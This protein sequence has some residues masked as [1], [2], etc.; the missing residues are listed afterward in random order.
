MIPW[1]IV[2]AETAPGGT[3]L[4][5]ARRG[6][7]WEVR[8][9]RA[10]LMSNRAHG[11]EDA[12][13]RLALREVPR[14]S[15]ILLGGLGLGYSL[16]ATLDLLP[17][18]GEVVLAEMSPSVVRWNRT[19]LA[20]LAGRPL[21][22]PRVR[23]FEGDVRD[24]IRGRAAY[25]AILLDVDNGPSAFVHDAN[26]GLYTRAGVRAAFE[27]LRTPGVLDRLVAHPRRA[28]PAAPARG[29]LRGVRAPGARPH[30][31]PQEARADRGREAVARDAPTPP[32]CC[33]STSRSGRRAPRSCASGRRRP[34][35]GEGRSCRC[36]TPA[37]ST[38][39]PRACSSSRWGR[40]RAR[41]TCCT[42]SRRS[43]RPR[44][45]G[46]RR[47]TTATRSGPW[48]RRETRA[49]SPPERL[50]A[51]LAEHVGWREQVPPLTS[52]QRVDGEYAYQ[53]AH[54]GEV[55]TLPARRVFLHEAR[56]IGHDAARATSRLF[57]RCGR[58]YYVRS[59]ARDLGRALG[60]RA[61]LAALRRTAIGPWSDP[62]AGVDV[63]VT[64]ERLFPW[65][66]ARV[67]DEDEAR[68]VAQGQPLPAAVVTPPTWSVP[69]GFPEP[70]GPVRAL[71]GGRLVAL[72]RRADDGTLA[73]FAN[74][75]GGL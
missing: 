23:L 25:D 69:A 57:L 18:G 53:K 11:S 67:L 36:A 4:E 59:L 8:A 17:P 33:C 56:F 58:G 21:D 6:G 62:G 22:D 46:A 54:R 15:R 10:T 19:H 43:T 9:D 3:R 24:R 7:E 13:P 49:T 40:R 35:P 29:G 37:R 5:L 48:S 60:C 44:W 71:S 63:A 64:G 20:D 42:T 28:V 12:L 39:S 68:R 66:S 75:R 74:L 51:A 31:R 26:A 27:A 1:V 38:R 30:R 50:E 47:R 72:L 2:E 70:D 34:R 65:L 16:R 41:S 32:G 45:P 52:A 14:A 55:F 61:H 73:P